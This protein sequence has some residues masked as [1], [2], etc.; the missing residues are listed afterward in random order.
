MTINWHD[1]ISPVLLSLKIGFVSSIAVFLLGT[2]AAWLMT[3]KRFYGKTLV[4]TAFLL[5]LVLP[6]TVVGFVLLIVIGRRGW[7]GEL[8]E[9][10]FDN[11]LVFTWWAG[12][13]ASIVISFPLVYMTIKTGFLSID[14]DLQDASRSIGA[15]EWQVLL[16][17][18]LPLSA[19]ALVSGYILGFARGLG[20]F[21]ATIMVAGNIPGKTQTVP[22]AI[23]VAVDNGK[24]MLA[25]Y[26]VIS[27][28]IT[29][30][31]ML[32]IANLKRN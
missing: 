4:E 17:V 20:E 11:T 1:F 27:I 16:W 26:W 6:P 2:A 22:T 32:L 15:G 13:L 10:L 29:S 12:V 18:T 24:T 3:I 23:Y 31:F 21:G 5:P 9:R 28:V 19:R 8:F 25:W 14:K 30:F 7:I